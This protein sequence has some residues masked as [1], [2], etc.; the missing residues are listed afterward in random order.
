MKNLPLMISLCLCAASSVA[1]DDAPSPPAPALASAAVPA[2]AAMPAP[3]VVPV[4]TAAAA[5]A[6]AARPRQAP[7]VASDQTGGTS[8]DASAPGAD[9]PKIVTE[10]K[11]GVAGYNND[12]VFYTIFVTNQDSRIVR[13]TTEIKG[14]YFE[15]GA[16]LTIADRQLTT[17]FPNQPTQV[18]IWSGMD[19]KSGATYSVK[20]HPA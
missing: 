20:C 7:V 9:A 18:G 3:A 2:S 5:P 4:P 14:F 11:W 17:V 13:C 19:E 15:N 12:E 6:R 1:E 10:S 8:A 16:K